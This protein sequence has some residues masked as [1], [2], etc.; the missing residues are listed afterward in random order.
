[1]SNIHVEYN[2]VRCTEQI[3]CSVAFLKGKRRKRRRTRD[4]TQGNGLKLVGDGV[5]LDIRERFITQRVAGHWNRL[6][7]EAVPAPA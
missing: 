5:R 3:P 6:P 1:M 7:R 4:S 2:T